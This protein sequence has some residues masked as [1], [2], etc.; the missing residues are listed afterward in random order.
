MDIITRAEAQ[1][2]GLQRYFTGK[3]CRHGHRSERLASNGRCCQCHATRQLAVYHSQTPEEKLAFNRKNARP[4]G[5]RKDASRRYEQKAY[6]EN[7]GFRI[8]KCLRARFYK[9]V[10]RD[11]RIGTTMQLVGCSAASLRAHLQDQFLPGMT[12]DNF[13]GWEIDHIRPCASFDLTDPAQ[14]RQCFHYTNLQ[15]LWAED[16]RRK[17]ATMAA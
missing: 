13:G 4:W 11:Q 8:A 1:A 6:R 5:Q 7:A 2:Q 14:Q 3:P 10:T 15:P 12:W 17:A 16:N 9:A